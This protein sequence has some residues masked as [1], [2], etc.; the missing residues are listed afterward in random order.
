MVSHELRTPLA[1]PDLGSGLLAGVEPGSETLSDES[2]S[3]LVGRRGSSGSPPQG[4]LACFGEAGL[5]R[6]WERGPGCR[7]P[8]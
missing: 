5:F 3:A 8:D 6:A 7:K 4:A 2:A 1:E